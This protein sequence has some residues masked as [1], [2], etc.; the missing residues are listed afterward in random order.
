MAVS[1]MRAELP[2]SYKFRVKLTGTSADFI[3]FLSKCCLTA[4]RFVLLA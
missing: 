3:P 4:S 1:A 2:E